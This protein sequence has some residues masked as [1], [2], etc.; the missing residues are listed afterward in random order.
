MKD[1]VKVV[2]GV[3]V[4]MGLSKLRAKEIAIDERLREMKE[5]ADPTLA[6]ELNIKSVE[7]IVKVVSDLEYISNDFFD[8]VKDPRQTLIDG[9]GDCEDFAVL[10]YSLL[11]KLY[12][13]GIVPKPHLA[14]A[15]SDDKVEAHAFTYYYDGVYHIFSNNQYLTRSSLRE[16]LDE[17]GDQHVRVL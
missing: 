8:V 6:D 10:T 1:L 12:N 15:Y 7:D 5:K 17:I 11:L 2:F 16:F 4:G 13:D 3:L 14:V 9:G